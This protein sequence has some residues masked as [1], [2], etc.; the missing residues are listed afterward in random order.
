MGVEKPVDQAIGLRPNAYIGQSISVGNTVH[1]A[2]RPVVRCAADVFR[3]LICV[4]VENIR[5]N[6]EG[7]QTEEV[8]EVVDISECW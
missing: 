8:S 6:A 5:Q 4:H 7:T 3:Q 1:I 2:V